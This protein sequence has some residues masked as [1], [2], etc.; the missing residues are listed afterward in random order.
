[1]IGAVFKKFRHPYKI[2]KDKEKLI[3]VCLS[4]IIILAATSVL[5]SIR[6]QAAESRRVTNSTT[7]SASVSVSV[8]SPEPN[9]SYGIGETPGV[10][11]PTSSQASELHSTAKANGFSDK[12]AEQFR[13][14]AIQYMQSG[15]ATADAAKANAHR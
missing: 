5:F 12:E 14:Q 2:M 4:A 9:R 13:V 8:S 3:S 11:Q 1:M 7:V 15:Q 10:V 6:K